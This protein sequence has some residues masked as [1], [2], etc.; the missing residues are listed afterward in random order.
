[1]E[2]NRGKSLQ[3]KGAIVTG[4]SSGIGREIALRLAAQGAKII[5]HYSSNS[6]GANEVT[7]AIKPGCARAVKANISDQAE[8]KSLFDA[9][10]DF[11]GKGNLHIVINNAG[12]MDFTYST[13]AEATAEAWDRVFA[14]NSRG[15]FLCCREAAQRV[16]RGGGGRIINITT[17]VVASVPPRYGVYAASKAAVETMTKILAKELRGTRITANCVAPGAVETQFFFAGKTP[18][19]VDAITKAA[20]LERLGRVEDIAPVVAFLASDEGEW[21]NAQVVRANGGVV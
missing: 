2:K 21:V 17:S 8:V 9:A 7:A 15:T 5:V 4:A 19:M 18:E 12:T 20:P 1:M 16:A 14:V 11:L 3:G 13:L 6:A 10:E